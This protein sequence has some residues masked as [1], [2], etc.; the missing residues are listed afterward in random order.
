MSGSPMTQQL[1]K[2]LVNLKSCHGGDLTWT[3]GAWHEVKG[4]LEACSRGLHL[5]T[6]PAYWWMD[7]C[8]VWPVAEALDVLGDSNARNGFKV[9]SRRV[10]LGDR[11]LNHEELVAL[12]IFHT[13]KHTVDST[14]AIA[15]VN[16]RV[17]ARGDSQ[18]L[19]RGSSQVFARGSS[20][21]VAWD[22]S[23]VEALDSSHVDAR[24]NSHVDARGDSRV[25]AL[26]SSHVVAWDNSRVDALDSS[27]VVA[28]GNSR[29]DARDNSHVD[30][31]GDSHV[32]ARGD[33]RV[34]ARGNSRVVARGNSQ[35]V[36]W[37]NSRVEVWSNSRVEAREN[38]NLILWSGT[39]TLHDAAAAIDRR[40]EAP[41][42]LTA[43]HAKG[44][45]Q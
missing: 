16:S 43:E 20:Q 11:P 27:H 35:V 2:V 37:N 36:A 1:Y 23:R 26:D 7:G 32:D 33:S 8:E 34:V 3:P 18:V 22:N 31:R 21:V 38:S 44:V 24:D 15:L 9:V 28:W 29:V 5:T 42:M 45:Q 14:R 17:E 12:N 6:H 4:E 19:A 41:K 25:E 40:S 30:A 39:A 10:K 13:G